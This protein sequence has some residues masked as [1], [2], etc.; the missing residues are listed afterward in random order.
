M[1]KWVKLYH[2]VYWGQSV[3]P[4]FVIYIL[5]GVMWCA[6]VDV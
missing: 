4:H 6:S 1:K 5:Y 3:L 2:L